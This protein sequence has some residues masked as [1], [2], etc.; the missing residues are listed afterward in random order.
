MV[1]GRRVVFN[2]AGLGVMYTQL[3]QTRNLVRRDKITLVISPHENHIGFQIFGDINGKSMIEA[4]VIEI[5]RQAGL[6]DLSL[7]GLH[8]DE[9]ERAHSYTIRGA[10][11]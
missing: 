9:N 4:H 3:E 11:M 7:T 2:N 1:E 10:I 6:V 8:R 5:E